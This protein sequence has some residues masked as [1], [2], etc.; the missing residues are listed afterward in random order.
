VAVEGREGVVGVD[1]PAELRLAVPVE[2]V[3]WHRGEVDSGP[4]AL[5][6]LCA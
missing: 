6:V 2:E 5:P 4:L 3:P 1:V